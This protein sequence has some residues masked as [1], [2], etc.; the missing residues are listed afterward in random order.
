M[1]IRS[2]VLAVLLIMFLACNNENGD[3]TQ[4]TLN[5]LH[6]IDDYP[7]YT[8]TYFRDYGLSNYLETGGIPAGIVNI[9]PYSCTCFIA[10]GSDSCRFFGRNFDWNGHIALLLYTNPPDGYASVSMVHLEPLGFSER[11]PIDDPDNRRAL[12]R[13]ATTPLDG[14]NE[15]GVAEREMLVNYSDPPFD[16]EKVTLHAGPAIRLVLDYAKNVNE[17]AEL[18]G[19]YN[20]DFGNAPDLHFLI[21]DSSGNSFGI[22]FLENE[23]KVIRN[24]ENWQ[25]CTNTI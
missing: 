6:K 1:I 3:D 14:M 13:A 8:M 2:I 23:M 9:H 11:D 4:N 12:L 17:A 16:P 19:N 15:C 5:S 7:F 21:S 22:E 24:S 25:V 10:K 18:L 20:I